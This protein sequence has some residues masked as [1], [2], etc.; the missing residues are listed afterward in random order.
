MNRRRSTSK[1]LWR[2]A[3]QPQSASWRRLG[4]PAKASNQ[5]ALAGW[6]VRS[7][8]GFKQRSGGLGFSSATTALRVL[9]GGTGFGLLDGCFQFDL[10]GGGFGFGFAG[11]LTFG[12]S[13]LR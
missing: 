11:D 7:Y 2:D 1:R 8:R 9:T 13:G 4:C 10:E 5:N 6:E 12:G 3:A